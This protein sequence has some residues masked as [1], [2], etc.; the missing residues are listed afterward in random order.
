MPQNRPQ[1]INLLSCFWLIRT[2]YAFYS[3]DIYQTALY[4]SGLMSLQLCYQYKSSLNLHSLKST[5]RGQLHLLVERINVWK[6]KFTWFSLDFKH[7]QII[8]HQWLRSQILSFP[9]YTMF[10]CFINYVHLL[11][12][13]HVMY[14]INASYVDFQCGYSDILG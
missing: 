13:W 12:Y 14:R 8:Y 3:L 2:N 5:S 9:C 6:S 4:Q 11:Y 1:V 10:V 7:Y